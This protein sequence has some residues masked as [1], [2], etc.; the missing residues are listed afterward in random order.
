MRKTG[1]VTTLAV[2]CASALLWSGCSSAQYAYDDYSY[3][4]SDT[5]W[6]SGYV[7]QQQVSC[8]PQ[9]PA[10]CEPACQPEPCAQSC[11]VGCPSCPPP[12]KPVPAN[13]SRS[14]YNTNCIENCGVKVTAK[15]PQLCM[16]G[17]NYLLDI[18]VQACRD[19]CEV[20]I[21]AMLPQ[22]VS[23]VR[24]E[25]EGVVSD[26]RQIKWFIEGMKSGETRTTRVTLRA[27]R[28][29]EMCVCFCVTA[30]PVQFCAM[31]CARPVLTCEKC[32]PL[33]VC[34]GDAV[35]YT[36][37]VTNQGSC[38]AEDVVVTDIVP[39][40]LRHASGQT[41]LTFNLGEVCP[42]SSKTVD[43]CFTAVERG[44]ACNVANV[45][46]CNAAS[47]SCQFCTCVC[48]CMCETTKTGPKE[49][50]IGGTATY[51]ITVTN[52]GDKVLTDVVICDCAPQATSI[53]D[54]KGAQVNGNQ[55]VWKF[56]ELRP[57]DKLATQITLTTCTPGYF[58]NRVNVNNAQGCPCS[59]EFGTRWKGAP[60]INA[61]IVSTENPICIGDTTSYL[62]RV[63]NQG[64]EE[65][66]NVAVTVRL[67]AQVTPTSASGATSGTI[68]G[69]TVTFAPI[70][71]LGSRN[72]AE[73]RVDAVARQ[74]GEGR[75]KVEV[76][77][78]TIKT[79]ITQEESQV[80]N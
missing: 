65:D 71:N 29:G 59:A 11:E 35:K 39:P 34:P 51:D 19:V 27:D 70:T 61:Q 54:A 46:A 44:K 9:C 24:S 64:S 17:E 63:L 73:Y 21:N 25:P 69:Q 2:L 68:N 36:I 4:Y 42:C 20:E 12:C 16:Q 47:T 6:D 80:V 49:A 55:A 58:V 7:E 10:P 75:V 52:Q 23:L 67:P 62:I 45:T 57:G 31:L 48:C 60:A 22:G 32:G 14:A 78:D 40:Q 38:V 76:S 56:K 43:V 66:H 77:S 13:V 72:T 30:V 50:K 28:E 5:T 41:T 26:G 15:Q 79:P 74:S 53:V 37:T 1:I 18:E 8:Q 33:E 3:D